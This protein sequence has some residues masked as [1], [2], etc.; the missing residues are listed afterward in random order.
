MYL[1]KILSF[2]NTAFFFFYRFDEK[3]ISR[4]RVMALIHVIYTHTVFSSSSHCSMVCERS[5]ELP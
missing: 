3:K 2:K 4:K 5:S 1:L